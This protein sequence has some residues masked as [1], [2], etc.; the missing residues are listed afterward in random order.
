MK[1][2]KSLLLMLAFT[3]GGYFTQAQYNA[4][5]SGTLSN[6]KPGDT[7][8]I[9]ID[10]LG[11]IF[12][13]ANGQGIAI[14]PN[15]S[16][17]VT[18]M[19]NGT[20]TLWVWTVDCKGDTLV[21]STVVSSARRQAIVN[22]NYCQN[23][24]PAQQNSIVSGTVYKGNAVASD[25]TVLL[26]EN[27]QGVL[28]AVDTFG[29]TAM[30]RGYYT[31]TLPDS[32]KTYLVKA[33][34]NLGNI[35]YFNYFP[36]YADSAMFWFFGNTL[37]SGPNKN[38]TRN[39]SL[40]SGANPGGPGFIGGLIAAGANKTAGEGDPIEGVQVMILKDKVPVKYAFSDAQGKFS[41]DDL[42][43]GTYTVHAE[44]AG[45]QTITADVSLSAENPKE[46]NVEVTVNSSGITTRIAT[47]SLVEHGISTF[48]VY[49]NPVIDELRINLGKVQES[50]HVEITDLSGR[51]IERVNAKQIN[52]LELDMSAQ[53]KGHYLVQI[54]TNSGFETL[55]VVKH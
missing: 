16:Y 46:E 42:A 6:M 41:I 48:S 15:G 3:L 50:V 23:T 54:Q 25:A 17:T 49:P 37:P 7:A 21:D 31:F 18:Y 29:L 45:L 34:L 52:E 33:F 51:T 4:T 10:S 28:T 32:T 5:V 43:Y 47:T 14:G 40:I 8:T 55:R 24:P 27:H 38:H 13:F 44:I 36:T 30:T 9:Y 1:N 35:D 20:H 22:F 11:G 19:G 26:I 39:V 2:L 12:S 53:E